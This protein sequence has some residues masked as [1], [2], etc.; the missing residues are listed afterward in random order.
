MEAAKESA[1]PGGGQEEKDLQQNRDVK[2]EGEQLTLKPKEVVGLREE[3]SPVIQSL[4]P[5]QSFRGSSNDES[6]LVGGSISSNQLWI[7]A[8]FYTMTKMI[9]LLSNF[10]TRA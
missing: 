2:G 3:L 4:L 1:F 10:I 8:L 5:F 9:Y 6:A 7:E